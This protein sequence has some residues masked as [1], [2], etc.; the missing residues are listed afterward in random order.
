MTQDIDTPVFKGQPTQEF[1]YI[2]THP[3]AKVVDLFFFH[4]EKIWAENKVLEELFV[5]GAL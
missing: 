4:I 2:Y 5:V 1:L 3:L